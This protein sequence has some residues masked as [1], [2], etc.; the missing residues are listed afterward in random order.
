MRLNNKHI[1]FREFSLIFRIEITKDAR[2]P[3]VIWRMVFVSAESAVVLLYDGVEQGGEYDVG[4]GIRGVDADA[5][6]EVLHSRLDHI[7]E[8]RV[9]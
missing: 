9:K 8:I 6:V 7:P 3:E 2:I 5:G 4:L 1:A